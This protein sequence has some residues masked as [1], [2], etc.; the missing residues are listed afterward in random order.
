M[1]WSTTISLR[2][3]KLNK[4]IRAENNGYW[5]YEGNTS[6]VRLRWSCSQNNRFCDLLNNNI[7]TWKPHEEQRDR[8]TSITCWFDDIK[9]YR[10][11]LDS[12]YSDRGELEPMLNFGR[13]GLSRPVRTSKWCRVTYEQGETVIWSDSNLYGCFSIEHI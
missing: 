11:E 6:K 12:T 4:L 8:E 3:R 13:T 9:S 7:I 5:Y 1:K 2:D 10:I